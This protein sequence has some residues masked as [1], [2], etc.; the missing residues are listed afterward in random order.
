[1]A[2][3]KTGSLGRTGVVASDCMQVIPRIDG[4]SGSSYS[5]RVLYYN[6]LMLYMPPGSWIRE[7]AIA[8]KLGLS[9]TPVHEAVALLNDR[10]LVDV[11][12][13]SA[14]HVSCI[15]ISMLRQGCF[16]RSS[17][18]PLVFK[19][20]AGSISNEYRTALSKNLEAQREIPAG[21]RPEDEYLYLDNI[22][23][24]L[25]YQA[26]G[27][28]FIWEQLRRASAPYD[29]VRY[30]GLLFGYDHPSIEDHEFLFRYLTRGGIPDE[31][32]LDLIHAHLAR[33][34]SFFDRL[35]TD[36]PEYFVFDE[37]QP[38]PI[39]SEEPMSLIV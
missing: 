28:D 33:Y 21:N 3:T 24:R 17:I 10:H 19:Q 2:S 4:E 11:A 23:H 37:E 31:E 32:V 6:I 29:R 22:F 8:Q 5:Y 1:M 18:E 38:D 27:K 20:V 14:T 15:D 26:A 25:V 16:L 36:F 13:Q 9:R 30:M 35:A 39:S 7:S 12:P 34:V